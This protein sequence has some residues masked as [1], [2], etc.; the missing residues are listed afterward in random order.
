VDFCEFWFNRFSSCSMRLIN[1][2]I[3]VSSC[4]TRF[5]RLSTYR[6]T[7]SGMDVPAID[8]LGLIGMK[9]LAAFIYRPQFSGLPI[10]RRMGGGM[11]VSGGAFCI[12]SPDSG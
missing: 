8:H 5:S 2:A 10:G 11:L 3:A 4:S 1:C 6:R 9:F 7:G 12:A